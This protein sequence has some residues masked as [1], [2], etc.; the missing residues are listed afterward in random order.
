MQ[1]YEIKITNPTPN[2]KERKLNAAIDRFGWYD[3]DIEH[4]NYGVGYTIT[5]KSNDQEIEHFCDAMKTNRVRKL[6]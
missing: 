3:A 1:T 5:V 6:S 2:A 4:W